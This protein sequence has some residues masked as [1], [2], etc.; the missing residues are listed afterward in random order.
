MLGI[1]V[2]G[3]RGLKGDGCVTKL[4]VICCSPHRHPV[5]LRDSV[6]LRRTGEGRTV[7]GWS[8]SIPLRLLEVSPAV[9]RFT[10]ANSRN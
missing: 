10:S 6:A 2:N 4:M 1:P 7:G 8:R 3:D 5:D 9:T